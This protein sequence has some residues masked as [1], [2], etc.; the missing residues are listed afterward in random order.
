[1]DY[2]GWIIHQLFQTAFVSHVACLCVGGSTAVWPDEVVPEWF[3]I[4]TQVLS[5]QTPA[6]VTC[7]VTRCWP[8]VMTN[9]AD[10][11]LQALECRYVRSSTLQWR[12]TSVTWPGEA[13]RGARNVFQWQE[14]TSRQTRGENGLMAPA[15]GSYT[16]VTE[17]G[18]TKIGSPPSTF[19]PSVTLTAT[20]WP[21]AIITGLSD[22]MQSDTHDTHHKD[23]LSCRT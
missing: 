6:Y 3:V 23:R 21:A 13:A 4:Y 10:L 11:E 16:A 18:P 14:V 1:M 12:L 17:E 7:H 20:T 19:S 5:S 2:T 8:R 22:G 9:V 15:N